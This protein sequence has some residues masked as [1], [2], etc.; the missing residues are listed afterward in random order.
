[1]VSPHEHTELVAGPLGGCRHSPQAST[2]LTPGFTSRSTGLPPGR[3]RIRRPLLV[4]ASRRSAP[5]G[6]L[7]GKPHRPTKQVAAG[8]VGRL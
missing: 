6:P 7:P 2:L 4:Q 3:R 1:M 5:L 8:R